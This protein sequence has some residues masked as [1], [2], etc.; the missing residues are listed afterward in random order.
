MTK[1][2]WTEKTWN[3][4]TGCTK[5]SEGCRNC[6]AERMA[7]RLA[8]RCGY[9][10]DDPFRP[11][12]VHEDKFSQPAGWK[13]P[14]MIFVSS[15]GDL[16]HKD[17]SDETIWRVLDVIRDCPQHTFQLLTKRAERLPEFNLFPENCWVGVTAESQR[18]FDERIPFLLSVHAPVRFVSCE[19]LLGAIR[20]PK[21]DGFSDTPFQLLIAHFL[22]LIALD[23]FITC[24]Y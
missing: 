1:I 15:M 21:D 23:D 7:K 13:R 18:R 2:E 3:P 11:G 12:T 6:Y 4:V 8:G 17:V 19:P 9:P 24:F 22:Q 16:F 20:F 5:I 14:C 10:A